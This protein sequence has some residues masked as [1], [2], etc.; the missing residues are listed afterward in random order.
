MPPEYR[1]SVPTYS[2]ANFLESIKNIDGISVNKIDTSSVDNLAELTKQ[3]I[4][5]LPLTTRI[6][7]LWSWN[8]KYYQIDTTPKSWLDFIQNLPSSEKTKITRSLA[9]LMSRNWKTLKPIAKWRS[10]DLTIQEAKDI[11]SESIDSSQMGDET[12]RFIKGF[13]YE[14]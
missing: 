9:V 1:I 14:S 11:P 3:E 13:L 12:K 7:S 5:K 6:S 4:N 2:D 8:R 10:S